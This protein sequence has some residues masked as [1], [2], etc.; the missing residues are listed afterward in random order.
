MPADR[1]HTYSFP[2]RRSLALLRPGDP[3]YPRGAGWWSSWDQPDGLFADQAVPSGPQ[4]ATIGDLRV[5]DRPSIGLLCSVRC[6]GNLA[7]ETYEFAKRTPHDGAVIIGGFHSPMERTC[8]DTLLVRHV[9]VVYCPARR[10]NDR[11]VPRAW[12]NA[13]AEQRLLIV[14]PFVDSQKRVTRDLAHRRNGFI[15]ALADLLFVPFAVRGGNTE[16]VVRGALQ[17]GA[18]V[19]TFPDVEN[20]HLLSLGARGIA[21]PELL[22]LAGLITPRPFP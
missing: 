8:L 1:A 3:R 17:R 16:A 6:P 15:A 19:C 14:S 22:S 21:L 2:S 11:G 13:L 5:F 10:L 20:E 9:P 18:R 12:E 4:L 7:L